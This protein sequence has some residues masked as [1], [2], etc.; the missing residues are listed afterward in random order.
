M[1][2][3]RRSPA[4]GAGSLEKTM[5]RIRNRIVSSLAAG[6]LSL[7]IAGC[8][9]NRDNSESSDSTG[10]TSSTGSTDSSGSTTATGNPSEVVPSIDGKIDRFA[11][12]STGTH[13]R[14]ANI[15]QRRVYPD[16]DGT[17]FIG[18]GPVGPPFTQADFDA[19]AALGANYVNISHP[20]LF[21]ENPPYQLD[22]AVQSNLDS[23]LD[24]AARA[25][26]FAVI[27]F[28][29]GPGR[30]EFSI[31]EGQDWFPQSLVNNHVWNDAAAQQAWAQMWST[32]ATRY[33]DRATVVG[34]DLMVEPNG[35][36]TQF[37]IWDPAEFYATRAGSLAD[38]NQMVTP[39]VA[40]IRAADVDTPILVS[41]SAYG[42]LNWLPFLA[43]TGDARTV[44][45]V[46]H[47]EPFEFSHQNPG[48]NVNYPGVLSVEGVATTVD[49]DWLSGLLQVVDEFKQSHGATVAINEFGV[50]RF[51][52]GAATYF[53]DQTELFE[54]R[55]I[56]YALWIWESSYPGLA[57][58]D[59]FNFR[60]GPNPLDHTDTSGSDLET[61]IRS[62]FARNRDRPAPVLN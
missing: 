21:T 58:V 49:R 11:L 51:A 6:L 39:I 42:N 47:Y 44:Y 35:P 5:Y 54:Q 30:S 1:N 55:G 60:H 23:L 3:N 62:A 10:S 25:G 8:P 7:T 43:P 40:A 14:G 37:D 12:W 27:S 17:D 57:T 13:L 20:G 2:R 36:S 15:Y 53:T 41:A 46:H 19:L 16:L 61:A 24:M 33:R 48:E 50:K 9:M 31:F 22:L 28:R 52:P 32:T 59:D 4:R 26:L 38:W 29:T 56:N 45:T 34:Y 18:P